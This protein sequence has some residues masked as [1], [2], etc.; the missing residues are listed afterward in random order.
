MFRRSTDL[1]TSV[2][3]LPKPVVQATNSNIFA[4]VSTHVAIAD[5]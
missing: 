3:L 5:G 4:E 1:A 2:R